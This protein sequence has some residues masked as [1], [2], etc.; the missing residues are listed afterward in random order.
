MRG[1]EETRH[2]WHALF[3]DNE[4]TPADLR[5][6]LKSEQGENLCNDGLRSICWKAFLL[7][8]DLDRT[9]WPR[10]ITDSRSA[11]SA[12]REHFLK[13]IEHPDDLESTVDPLADDEESPWQT[14]RRDEQMRADIFQDVERCLQEN[15]FFQEPETKQKMTDILFIYSKLNPDLGYRQGMHELLAPIL[16]VVDRDAADTGPLGEGDSTDEDDNDN[17][18]LQ[19]L[20]AAYV[21]HDSFSL[22]CSVMQTVRVYYEHSEQRSASGQMDV[23][24]IVARCQYVH[25]ELLTT[26]DSELADHLQTQDILPQ[27]FLTRWMRL[28]FGRE[29]TFEENLAVWD[30]LFAEGLRT[31]LIDFVCVAML[32]RIRWQLLE[33]DCSSALMLLLRYPSPVPHPPHEFVYDGVYLEQN[34]TADRGRFIISKYSGKPPGSLRSPSQSTARLAPIRKSRF[35][36]D[37]R[38]V[39]EGNS[40]AQSPGRNSPKGLETIFQDVSDGIQR[41][42]ET[43]GVAKAVRGA[44]SEARRNIQS[45]QTEA[46]FPSLSPR[47]A[48]W[49]ESTAVTNLK[50]RLDRLE[51][52]NRALAQTLSQSLNDLRS[53]LEKSESLDKDATKA[54]QQSLTRIQSVQTCLEDPSTP[55]KSTD[56]SSN[57]GDDTD[58]RKSPEKPMPTRVKPGES[59]KGDRP[60]Q[61]ATGSANVPASRSPVASEAKRRSTS[62]EASTSKTSLP[63]TRSSPRPPPRSLLAESEFSWM[64]GG[65]RQISSFVSSASVPPEQTRHRQNSNLFGSGDD[66]Q[67]KGEFEPDGLS[68]KMKSLRGSKKRES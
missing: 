48:A 33:A 41:R 45:I 18:M 14:L 39:S 46:N 17:D 6:A 59:I 23:I 27:I 37:F 7:F 53:Q 16:W 42:T 2:R 62:A 31:E 8:D 19:L 3:R 68:M 29:F 32:L 54:M 52:R 55:L 1:I 63:S 24:P 67:R 20:D 60:S 36:R 28:L 13:Y 58:E 38:G 30:T 57:A 49:Q 34:P 9:Q 15:F 11:Y 64:L 44:M 12:L 47:E 26:A 40:P 5:T 4:T 43:W 56:Q 35:R 22:F 25:D 61:T 65:G 21:E 66:D 50:S 10:K 51:D